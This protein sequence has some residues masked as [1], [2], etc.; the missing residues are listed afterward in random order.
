LNQSLEEYKNKRRAGANP[1]AQ[2]EL[3]VSSTWPYRKGDRVTYYI[4][5]PPITEQIVRGKP[6]MRPAKLSLS[7]LAKE[8][9]DY[10]NDYWV[11]HYVDRFI[12]V[13]KRLLVILGEDQ[14]RAI[15][16]DIKLKPAD[17]RKLQSEEDDE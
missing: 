12:T 3:A 14:F 6:V 2:Y 13:V 9:R 15:F 16:P 10:A 7:A 17:I 5:T 8:S 11:D 4:S 1:I